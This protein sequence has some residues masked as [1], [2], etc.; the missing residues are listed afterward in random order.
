MQDIDYTSILV[1]YYYQV[2]PAHPYLVNS[3]KLTQCRC[4]I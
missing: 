3:I 1:N 2:I 4:E